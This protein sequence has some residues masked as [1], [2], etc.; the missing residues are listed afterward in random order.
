VVD[1]PTELSQ[2]SADQ[3]S[4]DQDS[5]DQDSADQDGADADTT[6]E[7]GAGPTT[8]RMVMIPKQERATPLPTSPL[9]RL[10]DSLGAL[11]IRSLAAPTWLRRPRLPRLPAWL[12][13]RKHR[14]RRL[15]VGSASALLLL[16]VLATQLNGPFGGWLADES[17]AVLG[18]QATAQIES[19]YL[20]VRDSFN[21]AKYQLSGKP[22]A[23]PWS[24]DP[25]SSADDL[26]PH[27]RQYAM[28]L[29][30]IT[31]L[32]QP[33]LPGEGIWTTDDLPPPSSSQPPLAAKTFLRPDPARPYAIVT[34]LQLNLHYLSLHVVAGKSE[35]GGPL[36]NKGP[37]AIPD[38]DRQGDTLFAAFN[39]GFKYSDGRYGLMT[40]GTVY[41]PPQ[42]GAATIAV[43]TRGQVLLDAW[44]R[45][46]QLTTTNA[47][48]VAWR[49]NAALLIDHGQLNPLTSDGAAWGGVY[50]NK[51]YTW[52]SAI[53]ITDH[54]TLL[55]GAGD[56]LS[57]ATLGTAMQAAGATMAMQTDI[58]PFWVRCFLYHPSASGEMQTAK[59]HPGMQGMGAEYLQGTE[60]DFFYLT[61]IQP[62]TSPTNPATSPPTHHRGRD[63]SG[64][65]S[66][67]S[68]L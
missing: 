26:Q 65:Q 20:G 11:R 61:R 25:A 66:S 1:S 51:A 16:A 14:R 15:L 2:D 41:V 49:Q 48:L 44:G 34:L 59:L 7:P 5:A 50:L 10:R 40:N 45:D 12:R 23:A 68:K 13:G 43:T 6:V 39:G 21:Q 4:A 46:P 30:A 62:A 63:G 57:A 52:R 37:G 35:P 24:P 17:R 58:N 19:W 31:P 47:S 22:A 8:M 67:P 54:G 38:A 42:P 56:S 64:P 9:D 33:A 32:I 53:G 27:V 36:G 18:P 55:Y 29:P 3:D 60:R 28:P